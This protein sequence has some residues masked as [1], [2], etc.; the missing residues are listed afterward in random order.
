M[1][2]YW[3]ERRESKEEKEQEEVLELLRNDISYS[4]GF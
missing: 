2:L 3:R 1:D 4:M